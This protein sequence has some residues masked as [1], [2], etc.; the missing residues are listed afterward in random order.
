MLFLLSACTKISTPKHLQNI[1]Y[2]ITPAGNQQLDIYLPN[3]TKFEQTPVVVFIHG[4]GW[5]D[6][7]KST[8]KR[9]YRNRLSKKILEAGF[10]IVSINYRL[11]DG[12]TTFPSNIEDCKDAIRWLRKNADQ[13]NFDDN[14]IGI[15][16]VSSGATL[17]LLVG[18]TNDNQF[19]G[20][21]ELQNYSAEVNYII[22]GYGGTDLTQ[23]F[24]LNEN[25]TQKLSKQ[26]IADNNKRLQLL[27][28][29]DS[30]TQQ[31][32]IRE[33][34]R[35]FSPIN[36]VNESAPPILMLHGE[37][38]QLIPIEQSEHLKVKLDSVGVV[39]EFV[40][41]KNVKHTFK[42]MNKSQKKVLVD[43]VITFVE[44][45]RP[46]KSKI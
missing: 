9:T 29:L 27:F 8:I 32:E 16:G 37:A 24:L 2:K 22:D 36:Y 44:D 7:D 11:L 5:V 25:E 12:E 26:R 14:N 10:A 1:T 20:A 13:Y 40:P 19:V 18:L 43:S 6:S 42:V 31:K 21:S 45:K 35:L 23:L 46:K 34:L 3:K 30:K 41:F 33:K 15:Y 38:D 17:A 28:G 4:G 39:N